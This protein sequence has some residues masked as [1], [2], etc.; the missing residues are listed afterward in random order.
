VDIRVVKNR[1]NRI[2]GQILNVV[3]K[4]PLEATLPDHFQVYGGCRW[5]PIPYEEQTKMKEQQI[6]EVFH[7]IPELTKQTT[8]HPIQVS[9]EIHGYRNKVEF[10]WGKYIS[11]R[12]GI[13]EEYRFGFHAAGQFDRIIDCTYCALGDEI[14][15]TL[16]HIFDQFARESRLPTYDTKMYTGFWRHLVIRRGKKTN[17][18]MVILSVNTSFL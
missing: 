2:E 10:S 4:S 9:P 17:E 13:H 1:S 8:W 12:E 7:H 15:N 3:K 18:T 11:G 5:L 14:T 16:F 6:R